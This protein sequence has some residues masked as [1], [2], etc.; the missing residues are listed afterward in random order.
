MKAFTN[1]LLFIYCCQRCNL[2]KLR[3][4]ELVPRLV[5]ITFPL[6]PHLPYILKIE[7]FLKSHAKSNLQAGFYFKVK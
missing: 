6:S 7:I 5:K 2:L 3:S 1:T 4:T